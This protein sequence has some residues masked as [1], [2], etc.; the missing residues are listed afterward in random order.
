MQRWPYLISD[1]EITLRP[2]RYRD[3]LVWGQV[4]RVNSEWLAPWEATRPDVESDGQLP[5]FFE[6][7]RHYNR[8]ARELRSISFAIWLNEGGRESF[9]GQITLGGVVLGAYRGAHIGYWIDQRHA[10]RGYT[11]RAV[12]ALTNF[13][14]TEIRLHRIEINLRPENVAS[15][16]VAEKCGYTLEGVRPRYLHIAGEWRDHLTFVAEN[17]NNFT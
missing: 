1:H 15:R 10:N 13:A 11:T 12:T 5:T 4:R 14:F 17:P 3:R 16:K 9:I 7:I 8:E 2:I 6:M